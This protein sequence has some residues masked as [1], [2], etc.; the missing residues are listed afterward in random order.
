M[1][2][3][4]ITRTSEPP[5]FYT[6]MD[7]RLSSYRRI[8]SAP[9][10]LTTHHLR[11]RVHRWDWV[12]LPGMRFG[13]RLISAFILN[14]E[15]KVGALELIEFRLPLFSDDDDLM[16]LM[17][18]VCSRDAYLS[19]VLVRN[20]EAF[21]H[22]VSPAGSLVE[23]RTAWVHPDYRGGAEW[24]QLALGLVATEMS[25]HAIM[26]LQASPL[27]YVSEQ[28]MAADFASAGV[29]AFRPC[30]ATIIASWMS[31]RS[32]GW[33][34]VEDGCIGSIQRLLL[35]P[36]TLQVFRTKISE[37]VSNRLVS[38]LTPRTRSICLHPDVLR[39]IVSHL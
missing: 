39:A 24:C 30:G 4:R 20:W 12:A 1:A 19:E 29:I 14:G 6:D 5:S 2:R 26:L 36:F 32:M 3:N 8:L 27:E 31:Y 9:D 21:T 34:A 22:D 35:P 15:A 28:G 13:K 33:M 11:Y 23:F 17:D 38:P 10:V 7:P 37:V 25:D 16:A 18:L